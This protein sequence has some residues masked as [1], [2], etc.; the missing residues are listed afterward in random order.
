MENTL[1]QA[2][3]QHTRQRLSDL[4]REVRR[5][6]TDAGLVVVAALMALAALGCAVA[7]L[8]LL[9]APIIGAAAAALSAAAALL[10]VGG[11]TLWLRKSLARRAAVAS[12]RA[13]KDCG[14]LAEAAQLGFTANKAALLLAAL[15]AGAAAAT[16]QRGK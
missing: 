14:D 3:V 2:L 15:A 16:A 5:A 4:F 7:A 9:L 12:V 8:W 1:A 10:L 11:A 6:A 13:P